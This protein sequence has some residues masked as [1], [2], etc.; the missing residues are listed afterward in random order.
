MKREARSPTS[1]GNGIAIPHGDELHI[2]SSQILMFASER[3]IDWGTENV[4]L[5]FLIAIKT[6]DGNQFQQALRELY[7][8]L[9]DDFL[10]KQLKQ[11]TTSREAYRL[12]T[13][14]INERSH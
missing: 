3:P 7:G 12:L 8:V 10:I 14:F 11:T 4:S 5:L 2:K 6:S 1:V 13:S 9:K